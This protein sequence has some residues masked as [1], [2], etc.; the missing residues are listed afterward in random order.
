MI[1][2]VLAVGLLALRLR[3]DSYSTRRAYVGR[4]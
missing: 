2:I 3:L 4:H 1:R